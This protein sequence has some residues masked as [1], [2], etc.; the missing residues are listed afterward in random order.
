MRIAL[1]LAALLAAAPLAASQVGPEALD[2]LPPAQV[3]LLGEVHDN[4]QHHL[5]QARAVTAL[6]PKAL[7]FEMLTQDQ[8]SQATADLRGDPAALADALGWD[9]S[10]WPEFALYFPIFA[11]APEA[12]IYGAALPRDQ[13]RRA[14][15][16][17]AAAVFGEGAERFGL[18]DLLPK[19]EQSAREDGQARAH[20][21]ALPPSLLPGMVEAQRLRDAAF[22]R[23]ALRALAETGGPVAV[24]TGTG[25]V[26]KDWGMP[27]ALG[28]AAPDVAVLSLG[29]IE[30]GGVVAPDQP[31][32]LW[33]V[34]PPTPRPDPCA[35]LRGQG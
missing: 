19:A 34:T 32:D 26:R 8:A 29:Q 12:A 33:I 2:A 28:R 9:G 21:D 6:R 18:T 14:V 23:T 24:I 35:A 17:G 7:V 5:N 15:S 20:C 16:D 30:A 3:Y 31:Y 22:A 4:A 10:G 25:H 27:A 11:A 13:V 1:G